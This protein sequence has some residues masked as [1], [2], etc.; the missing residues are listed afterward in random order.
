MIDFRLTEDQKRLQETARRFA[1]NEIKPAAP[2][3]DRKQDPKDCYPKDIVQKWLDLGFNSLLVP[4]KYGGGGGK[5]LDLAIVIEEIG[6]ADAGM[7]ESFCVSAASA[8]CIAKY[9]TEEQK[10][11][12]LPLANKGL[13]AFAAT[14]PHSGSDLFCPFPDPEIGPKATCK[15]DGDHY[16]LNGT[17]CFITNGGVSKLYGILTRNDLSKPLMET[18]TI[19]FLE[20]GTPGFSIGKVEDKMGQRLMSNTELIMDNVQVSKENM[21]GEEGRGAVMVPDVLCITG[22]GTGAMAVGLARAAYETALEYAKQRITWKQPIINH[23]AVALMLA[24]MKMKIEAARNLVYKACWYYDN[25]PYPDIPLASMAKVFG[26]DVAME[27]TSNAV[28][29]LGGYGY[30]KEYPVE[31]YMRDAKILQIYDGTNQILRLGM[32]MEA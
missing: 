29:I 11:K 1:Q 20:E 31:K 14:E 25:H 24:D 28:Q 8:W 10:E 15:R 19:F 32:L 3:Y 9:G 5:V 21:L 23:Q 4:E 30:M 12:W 16:I 22:P 2:E 13:F 7:G 17:K 18:A 6:A 26:G 27:I